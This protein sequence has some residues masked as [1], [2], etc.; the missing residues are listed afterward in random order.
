MSCITKD[1]I[2]D[3]VKN[4]FSL[5]PVFKGCWNIST[6]NIFCTFII[7]LY[8]VAAESIFNSE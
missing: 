6:K 8:I 7:T 2:V 4:L 1:D 5:E 3:E